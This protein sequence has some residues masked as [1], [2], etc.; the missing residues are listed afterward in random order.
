MI[1]KK[2]EEELFIEGNRKQSKFKED[3]DNSEYSSIWWA[4]WAVY[5]DWRDSSKID[6]EG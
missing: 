5:D 4:K 3:H 2:Y 6:W 1:F